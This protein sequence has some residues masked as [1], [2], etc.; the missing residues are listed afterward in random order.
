MTDGLKDEHRTAIVN[1]LR[2]NERVERAVLFG[3]RAMKT[4][5]PGSDVDIA[6][7]GESLTIADSARLAAA[8]EAL[9]V[10]QR[11]D[12]LLHDGIEDATL[13][14]HIQRDGVEL[15]KR[16]ERVGCPAQR[17]EEFPGADRAAAP[18]TDERC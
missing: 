14:K 4:F 18:G 17:V 3:S 11:V 2:S 6:L 15:Y 10:P 9:T 12:L 5:T 16:Q 7:F 8:M 1:L 13:R